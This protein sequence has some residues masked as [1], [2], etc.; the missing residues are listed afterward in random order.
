MFVLVVLLL[1]FGVNW[2]KTNKTN[3][4]KLKQNKKCP[5]KYTT[6]TK[7]RSLASLYQTAGEAV[8]HNFTCSL[9]ETRE[10]FCFQNISWGIFRFVSKTAAGKRVYLGAFDIFKDIFGLFRFIL[11]QIGLF[12]LFWYISNT[13]TNQNKNFHWFWKLTETNTKQILF[14][15]V[16]VLTKN[17]FY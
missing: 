4:N 7:K 5:Q 13:E 16:L 10:R 15:L 2:T 17:L 6:K 1:S 14:R 12:R 3:Q 9:I 8:N 11:K